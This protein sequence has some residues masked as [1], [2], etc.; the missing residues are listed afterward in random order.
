MTQFYSKHNYSSTDP[1]GYGYNKLNNIVTELVPL[2][3]TLS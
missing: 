2:S 1:L 3:L